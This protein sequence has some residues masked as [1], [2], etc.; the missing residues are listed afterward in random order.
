[1]KNLY[2][3]SGNFLP[4]NPHNYQCH[5]NPFYYSLTVKWLTMLQS[6][7]SLSPDVREMLEGGWGGR[8]L[9]YIFTLWFYRFYFSVGQHI[10]MVSHRFPFVVM[11]NSHAILNRRRS[12]SIRLSVLTY[13]TYDIMSS[14]FRPRITCL[15][16]LSDVDW[17]LSISNIWP[18]LHADYHSSSS[19]R[20]SA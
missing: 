1:M 7:V 12:S 3:E 10:M 2:P 14:K 6:E 11:D 16:C 4:S 19:V 5:R 9:L 15:L 20:I 17:Q 13:L 8:A 18:H